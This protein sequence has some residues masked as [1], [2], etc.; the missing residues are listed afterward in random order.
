MEANMQQVEDRV[1]IDLST[2]T[3]MWWV[4]VAV[5]AALIFYAFIVLSFTIT[6][7]WAVALGL[8]I[9][10]IM[11]GVGQIAYASL[12]SPLRWLVVA[13]GALDIVLGI[14]AFAWPG[15]TFL[16]LARLVGWVLLFRGI[17][18]VGRA[19]EMRRLGSSDWWMLALLGALSIA[20]AFWAVRYVDTSIVLLVLWIGIALLTRGISA[21]IAGFALR[22]FGRQLA[23]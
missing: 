20:V 15:A 6:T 8:G 23:H 1:R 22:S 13:L 5:G 18:D 14:I 10:L 12:M 7:V 16:V 19:L 4:P 21:I 17:A 9:G 2:A 3:R 11:A